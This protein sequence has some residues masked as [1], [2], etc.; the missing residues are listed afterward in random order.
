[1]GVSEEAWIR[2]VSKAEYF[3]IIENCEIPQNTNQSGLIVYNRLGAIY[4]NNRPSVP[5]RTRAKSSGECCNYFKLLFS[6]SVVGDVVRTASQCHE[7]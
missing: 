7:N 2:T 4:W 5:Q 6:E 1:M 3:V